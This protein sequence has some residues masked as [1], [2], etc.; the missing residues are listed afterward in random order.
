VTRLPLAL[1]LLLA[2]L[3]LA[4]AALVIARRRPTTYSVP[5]EYGGALLQPDP[6]TPQSWTSP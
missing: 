4:I 1:A 3:A 2:I 6:Y 5:Y